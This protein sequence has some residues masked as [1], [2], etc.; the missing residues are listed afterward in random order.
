MSAVAAA[1]LPPLTD[2]LASE[3]QSLRK[4]PPPEIR[5]AI[6]E[7]A[8]LSRERIA[9]ELDVSESSIRRWETGEKRPRHQHAVAYS[10]LLGRIQTALST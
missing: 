4:L 10:E 5:R 3:I 7:Q 6:R 2:L 1:P 8:G 9:V